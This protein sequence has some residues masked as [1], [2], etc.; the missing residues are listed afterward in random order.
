[1][2]EKSLPATPTSGKARSAYSEGYALGPAH[3]G[4]AECYFGTEADEFEEGV[5]DRERD[6]DEALDDI[7]AWS[8]WTDEEARR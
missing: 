5:A 7:A 3:A 2:S 1:M 4:W 6:D 8:S